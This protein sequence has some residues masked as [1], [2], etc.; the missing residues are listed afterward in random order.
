M[1]E[2]KRNSRRDPAEVAAEEARLAGNTELA[3][4]PDGTYRISRLKIGEENKRYYQKD[5]KGA[6]VWQ[7]FPEAVI[8]PG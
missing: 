2:H 5:G 3:P 7:A 6:I 4:L 8:M 1:S